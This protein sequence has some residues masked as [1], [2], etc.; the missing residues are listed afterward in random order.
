MKKW[1]A[2][3]SDVDG[4]LFND[5]HEMTDNTLKALRKIIADGLLF[6][7]A[8]GRAPYGITWIADKYGLD[9]CFLSFGGALLL[10]ERRE[11]IFEQGLSK[12]EALEIAQF[13]KEQNFAIGYGVFNRDYWICSDKNNPGVIAEE[14]LIHCPSRAEPITSLKDDVIVDKVLCMCSPG[15]IMTI[16]DRMRERFPSLSITTSS[17]TLLEINKGGINKAEAL[18]KLCQIKGIDVENTIAFGDNYNDEPMLKAA[19]RGVL[20]SNAPDGL[21][22]KFT[23]LTADN[24]HD[25]IALE[26]ARLGLL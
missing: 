3:F 11:V 7:I 6:V 8:S 15:E 21:K 9:A 17:S 5:A 4:T 12:T 19:G 20:M 26:L 18:K 14:K 22:A 16:R 2:V 23:Y 25:G 24:N 13:A 10:D 1:Q